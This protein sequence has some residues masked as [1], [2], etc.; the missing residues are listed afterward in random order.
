MIFRSRETG[1]YYKIPGAEPV[2]AQNA[3]SYDPTVDQAA[4]KDSTARAIDFLKQFA[5]GRC[6]ILTDV[7][8]PRNEYRRRGSDRE[9]AS[10]CRWSRQSWTGSAPPTAT[11]STGVSAD[12]W[13]R[14]FLEAA[15]PEIRS[16][17]EKHRAAHS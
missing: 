9:P 4:V 6:V 16:C 8:V 13:S 11:T 5:K 17:L 15:G 1:A 10:A 14:A 3:V 7:P 12:R 2:V